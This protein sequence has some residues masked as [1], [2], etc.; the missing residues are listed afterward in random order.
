MEKTEPASEQSFWKSFI[1]WGKPQS[2]EGWIYDVV[3]IS[4]ATLMLFICIYVLQLF[5]SLKTIYSFQ[6]IYNLDNLQEH[7]ES[8]YI[9]LDQETRNIL[10]AP[11]NTPN[12]IIKG[13]V[14]PG[15]Q[16]FL[17][18]HNQ[19]IREVAA[20]EQG[21]FEISDVTLQPWSQAITVAASKN[22]TG[23]SGD[24]IE[25]EL[26]WAESAFEP[27]INLAIYIPEE[28]VLWIAGVASPG[29]E[30]NIET[31]DGDRFATLAANPVGVFEDFLSVVTP[32]PP[33]NV[34][35]K[36]ATGS[37]KV[38]Q[39]VTTI[40]WDA[41]PL[42]RI[43]D[44][45]LYEKG[46]D[47]NAQISLPTNHPYFRAIATESLPVDLLT[48]YSFGLFQEAITI[49]WDKPDI[50]LSG[51]T[52]T[53]TVHGFIAF[54]TLDE[55]FWQIR[56]EQGI[57][58]FPFLSENDRLTIYF[59]N[60]QL[61][62]YG[63]IYPTEADAEHATWVGPI[64][65]D[66][67]G[68]SLQMSLFPPENTKTLVSNSEEESPKKELLLDYWR[69]FQNRLREKQPFLYWTW[70]MLLYAIPFLALFLIRQ[71]HFIN[72]KNMWNWFI[73]VAVIFGLLRSWNYFYYLTLNYPE[74]WV[75]NFILPFTRWMTFSQKDEIATIF[76]NN[77]DTHG[78]SINIFWLLLVSLVALIP[79]YLL[80]K[81]QE[82]DNQ[83]NASEESKKISKTPSALSRRIRLAARLILAGLMIG[84]LRS[85]FL[86][87]EK[88][89][90]DYSEVAQQVGVDLQIGLLLV[91]LFALFLLSI[92]WRAILFG[93][94]LIFVSIWIS[95]QLG[96]VEAIYNKYFAKI[97]NKFLASI[98]DDIEPSILN[99]R[100]QEIPG[101]CVDVVLGI[102][103]I[104]L[105]SWLLSLIFPRL[106]KWNWVRW[107]VSTIVVGI[108]L[109][110]VEIPQF[111]LLLTGATIIIL[112]I[113]WL[114]LHTIRFHDPK[115]DRKNASETSD[116]KKM[117]ERWAPYLIW[118]ILSLLI[119]WPIAK[120]GDAHQFRTLYSLIDLLDN[121]FVHFLTF[122]TFCIMWF[123]IKDDES[124]FRN[125]ATLIAGSYIFAALV[126]NNYSTVMLLP[127][128]F[129]VAWWFGKRWVLR[130]ETEIN[131]I[132]TLMGEN[133]KQISK[134][135]KSFVNSAL[136]YRRLNAYQNSLKKKLE[137]GDEKPENYKTY[138][139]CYEEFLRQDLDLED[140]ETPQASRSEYAFSVGYGDIKKNLYAALKIG[141]LL[142]L[143]PLGIRAYDFLPS[144]ELAYP[145]PLTYL[146]S[147]LLYAVAKWII[148][149]FFF[150]YYYPHLRGNTGLAKGLWMSLWVILPSLS[151]FLVTFQ[152]LDGMKEFL[153][154]GIQVFVFLSLLGLLFDIN[155]LKSNEF[156]TR[157]ILTV[158]NMPKLIAFSSSILTVL[159]P[160]L[161]GWFG[162]SIGNISDL[163]EAVQPYI[164]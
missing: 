33:E 30:V 56:S 129:L 118:I 131:T 39:S 119:A 64:E 144:A 155:V 99:T 2:S 18:V 74:K 146:A 52:G 12:I 4:F 140:E 157:D 98:L 145:F 88:A 32:A 153:L 100:I 96:L 35:A 114:V 104:L 90:S 94:G 42:S 19:V 47:V 112:V 105:V 26:K 149:A 53:I 81:K 62:T 121:R 76:L 83:E 45:H 28:N 103:G 152:T 116:E 97:Y 10:Y 138:S 50:A 109:K 159:T 69:T 27:E 72:D 113:G 16:V 136:F 151:Y 106:G 82:V 95:S 86:I 60:F 21:I 117:S 23:E 133:P 31:E 15:D 29:A 154:W 122:I 43:F 24:S 156:R 101:W 55:I 80:S 3:R 123:Q 25:I 130:P 68:D 164:N 79:F 108:M 125:S 89:A 158:H 58:R 124:V 102:G 46:S 59:K 160:I 5:V 111:A 127:I 37:N 132:R 92:H 57:G 77:W 120:P 150:G 41:L 142:S 13:T 161:T 107:L 70:R 22:R 49:S 17:N 143:I 75:N 87:W 40:H 36:L 141:L 44:L 137:K 147:F 66:G 128:V 48:M 93:P 134:V 163:I 11:L 14:N 20:D 85:L 148:Y 8:R 61:D 34:I 110:L 63:Q 84:V 54:K 38:S 51:Q 71:Y 6:D 126:I 115:Q 73:K 162:S 65:L 67:Q 78:A 91:L 139:S 135:I 1:N 7:A 9:Q